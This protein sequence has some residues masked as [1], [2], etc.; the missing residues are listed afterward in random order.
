MSKL[1]LKTKSSNEEFINE[2]HGKF[3][4]IYLFIYLFMYLFI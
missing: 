2:M 3:P 1:K 4:N